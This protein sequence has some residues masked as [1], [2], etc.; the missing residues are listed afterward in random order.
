MTATIGHNSPGAIIVTKDV[1]DLVSGFLTE[2]PVIQ[3]GESARKAGGLVDNLR[4]CLQD[5]EDER[6][7][8]VKPLNSEVQQINGEYKRY[9]NTDK[10]KP[11]T[12]DKILLELRGRLTT[13]ALA[14]ESRRQAV[15]MEAVRVAEEAKSLAQ[16]AEARE[17]AVREGQ[18]VGEI[19]DIGQAIQ[20]TDEAIADAGLAHREAL[21]ADRNA[22]VRIGTGGRSIGLRTQETLVVDD[23]VKAVQ[24]IGEN[25]TITEAVQKAARAYR[26]LYGKLPGGVRS[27]QEKVI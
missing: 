7:A 15:V 27:V 4:K 20:E 5:I 10:K 3:D 6:E 11:G 17:T 14:E 2:T 22:T 19:A 18:S 26:S 8:K 23:V 1:V 16:A 9:H 25:D 13:F 12:Y 24:S 21:R